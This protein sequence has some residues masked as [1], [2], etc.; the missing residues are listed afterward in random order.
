MDKKNKTD[1]GKIFIEEDTNGN[2]FVGIS[3]DIDPN[4]FNPQ[5]MAMLNNICSLIQNIVEEA[6]LN[7]KGDE[8]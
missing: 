3:L 8:K 5:Q 7:N 2:D 6:V 4:I 1:I